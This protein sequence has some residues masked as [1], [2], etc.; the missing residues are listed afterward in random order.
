MPF[1]HTAARVGYVGGA[2]IRRPFL[3]L[4]ITLIEKGRPFGRPYTDVL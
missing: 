1:G 4:R 2:S 3:F